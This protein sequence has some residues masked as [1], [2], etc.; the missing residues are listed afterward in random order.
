MILSSPKAK[1]L[2]FK[3]KK[4]KK[5]PWTFSIITIHWAKPRSRKGKKCTDPSQNQCVYLNINTVTLI[6]ISQK[7]KH[8]TKLG[9]KKGAFLSVPILDRWWLQTLWDSKARQL[10]LGEREFVWNWVQIYRILF[11]FVSSHFSQFFFFF[12]FN[13]LFIWD[14]YTQQTVSE[15]LTEINNKQKKI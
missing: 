6:Q 13:F 5:K 9:K 4:K 7:N 14:T 12:F 10:F 11:V 15:S 3:P 2:K 1:N 8:K